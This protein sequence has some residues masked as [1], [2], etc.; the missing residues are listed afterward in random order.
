MIDNFAIAFFTICIIY[1]AFRAIK[2]ERASKESTVNTAKETESRQQQS[3][4]N[5][6][7]DKNPD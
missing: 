1:T 4:L 3:V 7:S 5:D 6:A 2:L